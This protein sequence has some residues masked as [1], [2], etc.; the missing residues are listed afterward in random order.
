MRYAMD[1]L[2]NPVIPRRGTSL[3]F[4]GGWTDAYPGSRIAFP[5]AELTFEAFRPVSERGSIYF[6]AA[7]G[8]VFG[9]HPGGLPLF[10]LGGPERLASYGLNQFLTDQYWYLRGGYLHQLGEMPKFLGNG[11]FL[12]VHYEVAKPYAFA[13]NITL[14]NDAV[15]G[16]VT[17]TVLGPV[18]VGASS[19]PDHHFK[20]FFQVGRVF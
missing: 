13:N 11:I 12:D 9:R 16:L 15:V 20:W 8:T 5:T 3:L 10:F 14:P 7:G 6:V 17:E 18:L 4:D 2:D 19:G 1:H